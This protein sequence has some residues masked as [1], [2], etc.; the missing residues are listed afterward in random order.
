M[1]S[2]LNEA[3]Q[4]IIAQTFAGLKGMT[5]KQVENKFDGLQQMLD[6]AG[7]AIPDDYKKSLQNYTKQVKGNIPQ[8][9]KAL[10]KAPSIPNETPLVEQK[11]SMLTR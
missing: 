10:E 8:I 9:V 6:N 2:F 4:E 3:P 1:Q 5:E 7:S 11:A